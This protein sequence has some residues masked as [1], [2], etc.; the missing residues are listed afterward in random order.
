MKQKILNLLKVLLL[1]LISL[2]LAIIFVYELLLEAS[3]FALNTIEKI[4][5]LK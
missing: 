4:I 1:P 2:T 3:N 5:N